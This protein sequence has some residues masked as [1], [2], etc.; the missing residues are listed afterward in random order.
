MKSPT[1]EIQTTTVPRMFAPRPFVL[2]RL[3]ALANQ[4]PRS[5]LPT[6]LAS[7]ERGG[8][9]EVKQAS[10]QVEY[11]LQLSASALRADSPRVEAERWVDHAVAT[12]HYPCG[13]DANFCGICGATPRRT[14]TSIGWTCFARRSAGT[15]WRSSASTSKS[16]RSMAWR[17]MQAG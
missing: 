5:G 16:C 12:G 15:R 2:R 10:I 17:T 11:A 1:S 8:D 6:L 13:P 3:R 9:F 4:Q 14:V 7:L